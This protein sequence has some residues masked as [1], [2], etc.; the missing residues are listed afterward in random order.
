MSCFIDKSNLPQKRVSSLICGTEDEKIL[1]FFHCRNIKVIKNYP[2]TKIDPAVSLHA[3]MAVLHLGQEKVIIDSQQNVLSDTLKMLGMEV[4]VTDKPVMGIY[5]YDVGL[6]FAVFDSFAVG[7]FRCIDNNTD[8]LLKNKKR[9][10]VNQGYCKCSVLIVNENA[11][12]TDDSSIHSR[13]LKN[14]IDSLLVS[15]GD[16]AL[17][18]HNYGFIGG[19]S[20]KISKDEIIFFGNIR[21][22]IDYEKIKS[23]L[24][25]YDCRICCTDSGELRDIGGIIPLTEE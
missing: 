5:P 14:G 9:I 23:F 6:N 8:T 24:E 3:D 10:N 7:N 13:M 11:V 17:E 19:A 21:K 18:G 22:H 1:D 20:G 12:I 2:N 16:I 4:F 25:K 15:K